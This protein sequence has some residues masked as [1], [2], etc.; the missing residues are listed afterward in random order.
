[1]PAPDYAA[2]IRA[3]EAGMATGEATIESD[4]DR[5]TYRSV[6]DIQTAL[7]YFQRRAAD[8]LSPRTRSGSTYAAFD[9]R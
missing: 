1:M 9:P 5:V 4:G 3:L 2:E 6:S 7:A 8:A